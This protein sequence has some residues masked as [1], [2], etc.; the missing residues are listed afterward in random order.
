MLRCIQLFHS[1][2]HIIQA[3]VYRNIFEVKNIKSNTTDQNLSFHIS[4]ILVT[5]YSHVVLLCKIN[6]VVNCLETVDYQKT[7]CSLRETNCAYQDHY[8]L[9][10]MLDRELGSTIWCKHLALS[11]T[12][13][14]LRCTQ[15]MAIIS[16]QVKQ[17][18]LSIPVKIYTQFPFSIECGFFCSK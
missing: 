12:C 6:Y 13:M 8:H 15:S 18:I 9:L 1:P 17:I 4:K 5:E 16:V 7:G 10:T 2:N 14:C 3:E 11:R